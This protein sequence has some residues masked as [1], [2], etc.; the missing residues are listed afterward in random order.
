ML[1]DI[2]LPRMQNVHVN[3]IFFCSQ[4]PFVIFCYVCE[5]QLLMLILH[6][7]HLVPFLARIFLSYLTFCIDNYFDYE[8]SFPSFFLL[9]ILLHLL[10]SCI[11]L[12]DN[13]KTGVEVLPCSC[14]CEEPLRVL[15]INVMM[16]TMG[17]FL[18]LEDFLLWGE[19]II[20]LFPLY[21]VVEHH[22]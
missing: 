20:L 9:W 12:A 2:P 4:K 19:D 6:S 10:L 16:L 5:W 18:V 17:L 3:S 11:G 13:W 14:S 15:I 1:P 7:A 22:E 8:H 21:Q